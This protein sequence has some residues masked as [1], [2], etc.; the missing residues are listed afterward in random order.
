L[1]A[2]GQAQGQEEEEERQGALRQQA[3]P[4]LS[5]PHSEF[6]EQDHINNDLHQGAVLP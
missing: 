3:P 6:L 2:Q 1:L 4:T 5:L